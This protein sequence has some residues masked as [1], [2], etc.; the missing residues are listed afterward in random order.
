[1]PWANGSGIPSKGDHPEVLFYCVDG[2]SVMNIY[3]G[4]S[5]LC[6]SA[7]AHTRFLVTFGISTRIR[8]NMSYHDPFGE[9]QTVNRWIFDRPLGNPRYN[10]MLI[11]GKVYLPLK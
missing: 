4:W 11:T 5:V 3:S 10:T 2:F 1:M 6:I 8:L 9:Y 7:I